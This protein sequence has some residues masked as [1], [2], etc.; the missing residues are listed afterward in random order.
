MTTGDFEKI[1]ILLDLRRYAAARDA[2]FAGL[3]AAPDDPRLTWCAARA[4][5]G[6]GEHR[7]AV[8]LVRA[9]IG[10]H[11]DDASLHDLAG[12]LLLDSGRWS[13]AASAAR[14]AVRLQPDSPAM[15][16]LAA[17]AIA[18]T[19]RHLKEAR[20]LSERA[21]AL[22][23]LNPSRHLD[24]SAAYVPGAGARSTREHLAQAQAAVARALELDPDNP[25]AVHELARLERARGRVL[26]SVR[27]QLRALR[28]RPGEADIEALHR[29]FDS[30]ASLLVIGLF[31]VLL[32]AVAPAIGAGGRNPDLSRGW[33][34]WIVAAPVLAVSTW[35]LWR[36]ARLLAP[37][38]LVHLRSWLRQG[39]HRSAALFVFGALWVVAL[40]APLIPG[41]WRGRTALAACLLGAAGLLA[42]ALVLKL[43]G[44]GGRSDRH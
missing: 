44:R 22:E 40:V 37:D 30:V 28:A 15:L 9:A 7:E 29:N 6:L 23:P 4:L 10:A 18:S 1:V 14:E 39:T 33:V 11:P 43:A 21:V 26:G 34:A 19:G 27:L 36:L 16:G 8:A 13:E 20:E 41:E 32:P 24:R 3:R 31:L 2:A 42:H 25:D 17:R 12:R 35:V 38:P 5:G